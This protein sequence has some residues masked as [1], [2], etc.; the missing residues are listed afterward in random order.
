MPNNKDYV[1]LANCLTDDVFSLFADFKCEHPM[2]KSIQ[3]LLLELKDKL[4]NRP[5]DYVIFQFRHLT[6]KL[7]G[8]L[9]EKAIKCLRFYDKR[10]PFLEQGE[11][12][13]KKPKAYGIDEL[14]EYYRRYNDF[15]QLLYGS[16]QYYRDHV[17]HVIR[18]WLS[19]VELLVKNP[20]NSPFIECI[21]IHEKNYTPVLN[22]AE[23]LSV[24]TLI[25]LTHDL[26]YPLQISKQVIDKTRAMVSTFIT[27]PDISVDFSFHGVQNYMNDF[28]VRL[29]SSKMT[30]DKATKEN[31]NNCSRRC[32]CV[33]QSECSIESVCAN[34]M[35]IARLQ[36][37]YYFKFQK[38][39][40]QNQHGILSTLIIYK[41]LTYFLESDYNINEDYKFDTEERRQFYIR[42]EIL[43][44]IACHTCD[45][46]YQLYLASFSFLLRVCDDTQ[47][48]GRKNITELY[49]KSDTAAVIND[50]DFVIDESTTT[51]K[52]HKCT[53]TEEITVSGNIDAVSSL[54]ERF[55]K[56]ALIY[57]TVFRD[58][59]DTSKRDFSFIRKLKIKYEG[60][61]KIELTLSI[62]RDEASSLAGSIK[63]NSDGTNNEIFGKTFFDEIECLERNE[64]NKKHGF[65]VML[66]DDNEIIFDPSKTAK[67]PEAKLWRRG[68]FALSLAT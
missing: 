32:D 47:E 25:A 45:D 38:S 22:Y 48:W 8:V 65:G 64:I 3:N 61:D 9:I 66:Y 27:S 17:I 41:M 30:F 59:Q 14:K 15:E 44:S 67:L 52:T 7:W 12:S 36:P 34:I 5:D 19:G 42:R 53:I 16:N 1:M 57:V 43:R 20:T 2:D 18:T 63:Y 62:T 37:K 39:L 51:V 40:E 33:I 31:T 50:I 23:K 13:V 24:W 35:S 56:Q 54:I 60:I 10:E 58:G 29:I 28:I 49:V 46:V 26:G 55:R 21:E 68:E 11:A 4:E 6:D